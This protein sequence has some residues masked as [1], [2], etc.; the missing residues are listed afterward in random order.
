[1]NINDF[2]RNFENS[3]ENIEANS[4][5]TETKFKEIEQWD[6]LALLTTLAMIDSEYKVALTAEEIDQCITIADLLDLTK[7]KAAK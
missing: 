4:L 5:T 1:M 2:L 3:I 6:S 7:L